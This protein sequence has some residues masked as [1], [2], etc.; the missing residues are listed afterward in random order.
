MFKTEKVYYQDQFL[1]SCRAIVV[2]KE[3]NKI[4]LDRT[5]AFP[6]GGGQI[7]DVGTII[8]KNKEIPFFDTKKGVGRLLS[9]EE[10]PNIQVDTPV[11]HFVSNE[12]ANIFSVGDEVFVKINLTHRI[13]TTVLHTALHLALMAAK[14]RKPDLTRIIKGCKITTDNARIDFFAKEKFSS[15]DIQWISNRVN[16]LVIEAIPIYVYPHPDEKEAWYWKCLDFT[17]ACGGTHLTNTQQAGT[18]FVKRKNVGKTT[19]R[20]IV[21]AT[22]IKLNETEYH[23]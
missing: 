16:E 22:D 14:E 2:G 23:G 11:Y 9:L 5:V 18:L 20:L 6:E 12:D 19:E 13:K 1:H 21:T 7:G 4:I 17:C 15:E 3:E 10:F 8:V